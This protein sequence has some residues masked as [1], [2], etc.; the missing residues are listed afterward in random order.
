[1]AIINQNSVLLVVLYKKTIIESS[2]LN[3]FINQCS[4]FHSKVSLIIWDNS[5]YSQEGSLEIPLYI[6]YKY[7]NKNNE[8]LSVIYNY[9]SNL[10]P[11]T[12]IHIFDQDSYIDNKY[13]SK[14]FDAV[15]HNPSINL[16]IPYIKR[17]Y[18]YESPAKR[19]LHKGV[20]NKQLSIGIN[21]SSKL[22]CIASG[23]SI[24]TN[25]II[26]NVPFDENLNFYGI[27]SKFCIDYSKIYKYYYLLDY[28]LHHNLSKYEKEEFRIK[29]WRLNNQ[30]KAILYIAKRISIIAFVSGCIGCVRQY[31]K[32]LLNFIAKK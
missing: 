10:Y 2:T 1:M 24:R 4:E 6:K 32:F 22:L 17:G 15:N 26:N 13:F 27:D 21:Q 25:C 12:V 14:V 9:I 16:F 31:I 11:D 29:F 30:N 28:E 5:P 19:V 8:K 18:F 7:Y 23:M 20:F 3:S